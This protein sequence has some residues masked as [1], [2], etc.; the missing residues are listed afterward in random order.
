MGDDVLDV[1]GG[2]GGLTAKLDD[3]LLAARLIDEAG[4]TSGTTARHLGGL[5]LSG[6]VLQATILCPAEVASVEGAVTT[7]SGLAVAMELEMEGLSTLTVHAVQTYRDLDEALAALAD[8][9]AF[10]GGW[11]VGGALPLLALGGVAFLAS[12]PLLAAL[13]VANGDALLEGGLETLYDNPWL[14]EAL[15]QMAPGMVQGTM[16]SL[17]LGDPRLLALISGGHWPSADYEESILGLLA[18]AGHGGL[19]QDTGSWDAEA[20][21]DPRALDLSQE[22]FL[23]QIMQQQRRLGS[24]D[25]HVQIITV[26]RGDGLPPSYIVQIPGTQV[27]DPHRGDNPVDV[28]TNVHLM[29]QAGQTQMEAAVIRAM[30]A[31]GI[32]PDAPIML[33][34]HSQGGITAASLASSADFQDRYPGLQS[35]VTAGSPIGNFDIPDNVQVMSLEHTQDVVPMLD[36]NANPDQPNWTTI[37]RNLQ[38]GDAPIQTPS[39]GA[40]HDLDNYADTGALADG[41]DNDSITA[42][43][44]A[45]SEFFSGTASGQDYALTPQGG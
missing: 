36:G 12:N 30:E 17:L 43:Q 37:V 6:D 42:W 9:A 33:T 20:D 45:N 16:S 35:V 44:A 4:D 38:D 39:L 21:G 18:L 32:P 19:L 13:L 8:G 11:M 1:H 27:W 3:L 25:G 31:A 29:S 14:L 5:I 7:A 34:G 28:T 22:D 40:A 23:E 2:A 15:T 24:L 10:V 26:D 41:S